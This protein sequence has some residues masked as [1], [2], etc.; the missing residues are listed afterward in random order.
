MALTN[1]ENYKTRERNATK[2]S[3]S[4]DSFCIFLTF[5]LFSCCDL[6]HGAYLRDDNT[7]APGGRL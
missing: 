2:L 7:N 4:L 3:I 5:R 1:G 6:P